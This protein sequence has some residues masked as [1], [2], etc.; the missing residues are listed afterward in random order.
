MKDDKLHLISKLFQNDEIRTVWNSGEEKYY[1]SVIDIISVL[2][3]SIRPRKYWSD[4]K[5]Q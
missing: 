2:T 3:K 1:T 4:L 5:K